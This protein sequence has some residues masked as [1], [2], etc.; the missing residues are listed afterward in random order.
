M[1]PFSKLRPSYLHMNS[2]YTAGSLY[3]S[4]FNSNGKA[5]F[6][7]KL[8]NNVFSNL[9]PSFTY[10]LPDLLKD[11]S[12]IISVFILKFINFAIGSKLIKLCGSG[13]FFSILNSSYSFIKLLCSG[14]LILSGNGLSSKNFIAI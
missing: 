11:T 4:S 7:C 5:L 2:L 13:K 3:F 14:I 9:F 8:S 10:I 1:Q 12:S 6:F